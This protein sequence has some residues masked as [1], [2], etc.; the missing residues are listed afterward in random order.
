MTEHDEVR[1]DLGTDLA[2]ELG[3]EPA[4]SA[5]GRDDAPV[6][7]RPRSR[8]R[9]LRRKV[10]AVAVLFGALATMRGTAKCGWS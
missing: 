3:F 7:S 5:T 9:G 10:S 6:T 8:R 1:D 2:T 4:V